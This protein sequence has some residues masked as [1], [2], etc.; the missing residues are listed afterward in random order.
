M[1]SIGGGNYIISTI[2]LCPKKLLTNWI[3]EDNK[4]RCKPRLNLNRN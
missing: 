4:E 1:M 3:F 2:R